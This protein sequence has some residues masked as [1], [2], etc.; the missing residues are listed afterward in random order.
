MLTVAAYSRA[1]LGARLAGPGIHLQT[2]AFVTCVKSTVARVAD[3]IS[4]LYADYPV[5][6]QAEFADFHVSLHQAGGLRRWFRPQVRL[7]YDGTSP[8]QPLPVAQ[9]FPMFEWTLNWCVSSNAHRYLCIH[10]AVVEKNGHAVILPA[11]PGS[12]KSTLCAALVSRG[13]RLLSDELT[14]VRLGTGDLVPLARPISLKNA[15]ID[16]IRRYAPNSVFS[17]VVDDTI[18]G[19]IAHL[20]APADSVARASQCARPAWVIFPKYTAGASAQLQPITPARA[21]MRLADNAF[22]YSLLGSAGFAALAGVIDTSLSY[23]FTYSA[24]DDAIDIFSR[25]TPP[26]Q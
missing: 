17:P 20:K 1:Q 23:E 16:I 13:W 25:L 9:A 12:G 21:F 14:L 8:F 6:E 3:G 22:N 2:G 15:S 4:L 24:L 7:D 10:A 18:K 11:P 5:L 26:G 19:S